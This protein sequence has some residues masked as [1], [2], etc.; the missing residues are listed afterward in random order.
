MESLIKY[1]C[2]E[3]QFQEG[4]KWVINPLYAR[5]FPKMGGLLCGVLYA[6]GE[7]ECF[8]KI[9]CYFITR[10]CTILDSISSCLV[11]TSYSSCSRSYHLWSYSAPVL[12]LSV[13]RNGHA[14]LYRRNGMGWK[15]YCFLHPTIRNITC[16][17]L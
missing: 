11:R 2:R 3:N 10:D 14:F 8:S 16:S 7:K 9:L 17:L 6:V 5:G 13:E 1:T 15:R 12:I 4:V